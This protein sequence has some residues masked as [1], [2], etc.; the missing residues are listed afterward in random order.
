MV[1]GLLWK[2]HRKLWYLTVPTVQ[3]YPKIGN[4][5]LKLVLV[6]VMVIVMVMIIVLVVFVVVVFAVVVSAKRRP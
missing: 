5:T 4:S 2:A 1:C 6:N 3:K